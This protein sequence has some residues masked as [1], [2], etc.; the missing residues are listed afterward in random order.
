MAFFSILL[1]PVGEPPHLPAKVQSIRPTLKETVSGNVD[2]RIGIVG[3][4]RLR[5]DIIGCR[6]DRAQQPDLAGP[7]IE[8]I[9]VA[10]IGNDGHAEF[11]AA[12]ARIDV[13]NTEIGLTAMG[14]SKWITMVTEP[15]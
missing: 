11:D 14:Y 3:V 7:L 13:V 9:D 6:D 4:T 1:Q 2:G 15:A 12:V 10:R 5:V 8:R